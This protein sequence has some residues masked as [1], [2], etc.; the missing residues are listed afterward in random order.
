ML[1]PRSTAKLGMKRF[2]ASGLK[3]AACTALPTVPPVTGTWYQ[4]TAAWLAELP[5]TVWEFQ[6][7][8]TPPR[9]VYWFCTI[10]RMPSASR[11]LPFLDGTA[12]GGLA[13]VVAVVES[14]GP[15]NVELAVFAQSTW[16]LQTRTRFVQPQTDVK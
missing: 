6:S 14:V 16:K 13:H 1:F 9:F 4:R 10:S 3:L 12:L 8:S 11:S 5:W 2:A 7:D 15:L